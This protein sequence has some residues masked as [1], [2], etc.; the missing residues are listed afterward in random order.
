VQRQAALAAI[1][2]VLAQALM[3]DGARYATPYNFV[4]AL[5]RRSIK[6]AMP[7]RADA[8]QLLTVHGAKGLE[9]AA[10]FVMDSDPQPKNTDTATL[11]IDWPVEAES[12]RRCAFVYAETACPRSLA[13][14]LAAEV[15]ARRRE[16]LNGLYVAMSRAKQRLVF[17]ATEP[18]RMA[19]GRAWWARVEPLARPWPTQDTPDDAGSRD[20]AATS[21]ALRTMAALPSR[22]S[23]AAPV[24]CGADDDATRLGRAVHCAL[25]WATRAVPPASGPVLGELAQAAANE[26]DSVP[27]ATEQLTR[28][29]LESA[30]CARFFA[31]PA[32][33]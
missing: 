27:G 13:D 20:A 22:E 5:K 17:S 32:L 21:F 15:Q 12:P 31:G 30:D 6:V 19:V 10:V 4:R 28:R 29:I 1:D 14:L 7:K 9:A 25:E 2:A 18:S 11:L 33:R 3:L 24:A 26:F 23:A 8:V 16:E